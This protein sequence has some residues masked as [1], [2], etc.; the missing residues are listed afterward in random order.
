MNSNLKAYVKENLPKTVRYNPESKG[1]LIGLPKPY[2]V[3]SVSDHFQ[4]MYYWDTYFLN[5]GLIILGNTEQAKNNAENMFYLINKY[6]FMPNGNRFFYLHNSQPP[7]LSRMTDDIYEATKDKEWLK[8]A[9]KVLKKEY[10]F[11]DTNRKTPIGL[12]QYTGNRQMAIDEGMYEGFLNRIGSRPENITDE[13]LSCQ[14]VAI[15]ES[16]WDINPRFDFRVEDFCNVEL[17]ALLYGFEMNMAKFCDILG[18]SGKEE[19]IEKAENRKALMNKYMLK[20]GIFYDYDFVNGKLSDK[21]TCASYY[22]LMVGLATDEQAKSARDALS[23]LETEYG[24]PATEKMYDADKYR[25]QWQY[26]NGWAPLYSI[27]IQGL[28]RYGYTSD[29]K[30]IGAK[31]MLLME[32]TFTETGNLWEKYNVV[33]GSIDVKYESS[34]QNSEMPHMIGW[35]AGVYIEADKY[36]S[37]H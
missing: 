7:F 36:V 27:I 23:R 34:G 9:F 24:I 12:S 19:W 4:E 28:D 33:N 37:E 17:N 13:K 10:L 26:P 3:P 22:P 31:Y 32:K 30:R 8:T 1:T 2:N 11:W 20:D 35:T 14:Y 6:G 5:R 21:F 15:C 18:E 29:A 16:G 25:Y